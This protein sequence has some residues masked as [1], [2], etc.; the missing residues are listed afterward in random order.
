MGTRSAIAVLF[1]SLMFPLYSFDHSRLD[2]LLH[3]LEQHNK[4]MGSICIAQ[5]G[6]IL[7]QHASGYRD[8]QGENKLLADTGTIYRIGS[9]TKIFTAAIILQLAEEGKLDLSDKLDKYFPAIPNAN[10][11]T[12]RH[13]LQHR[14][15]LYN[16]TDSPEYSSWL[17]IPKTREEMLEI[18]GGNEPIFEPGHSASYS[19]S[20]FVLL[21][22]IVEDITGMSYNEALQEKICKKAGLHSTQVAGPIQPENNESRS[23]GWFIHWMRQPETYPGIPGGAGAI[24]ST[25]ADLSRFAAA[26]FGEKL[27]SRASLEEMMQITDGFG[28]G[29]IKFPFHDKISYGHTGGIDGFHSILAWFPEE[30]LALAMCVNALSYP[31]NDI[32]IGAL[33]IA[34]DMPYT[35]PSFD[36]LAPGRLILKITQEHTAASNSP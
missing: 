21:G 30:K 34:F 14:S 2:S 6:H 23:F 26:L 13:L 10:K 12:L 7:Y 36:E 33:S 5:D 11:I 35:L 17:D 9:V 4:A 32:L 3:I 25:P 18:I 27:I 29:M 8:V 1:L 20:N 16:F 19:N 28:L 15:G 24:S 22:Y 31:F